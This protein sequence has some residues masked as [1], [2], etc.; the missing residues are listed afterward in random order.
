[1][2]YLLPDGRSGRAVLLQQVWDLAGLGLAAV[3]F[4]SA[5]KGGGDCLRADVF[6]ALLADGLKASGDCLRADSFGA[7][8]ADGL[9]ASGDCLQA[10]GFGALLANGLKAGGDC[11]RASGR[12]GFRLNGLY[13][14]K[15]G[16]VIKYDVLFVIA[17]P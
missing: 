4:C 10:D 7:L 9:K 11:L 3:D 8:L 15:E 13:E 14:R 5:V 16:V 1:M 17:I 6:G 12:G 2:V